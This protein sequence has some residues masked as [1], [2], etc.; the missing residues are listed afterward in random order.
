ML[1]LGEVRI[2]RSQMA[3]RNQR[4][5][6]QQAN[7]WMNWCGRHTSDVVDDTHRKWD[8]RRRTD[9]H[10]LTHLRERDRRGCAVVAAADADVAKERWNHHRAQYT[11]RPR[12]KQDR[13]SK[14]YFR[15]RS[16]WVSD[17]E[18]KGEESVLRLV[19]NSLNKREKGADLLMKCTKCTWWTGALAGGGGGV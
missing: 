18:E 9:T 1:W 5:C 2:E 6:A 14:D 10:S 16:A 3:E 17:T 19:C 7:A 15:F 4:G 8:R 12:Q 13:Q 11:P